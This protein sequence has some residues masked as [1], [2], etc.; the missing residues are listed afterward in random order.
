MFNIFF[1]YFS[2]C[3]AD[4]CCF[5][6]LLLISKFQ[7]KGQGVYIFN[8]SKFRYYR[9]QHFF[10]YQISPE[11]YIFIISLHLYIQKNM[12]FSGI[13]RFSIKNQES[14]LNEKTWKKMY[15]ILGNYLNTKFFIWIVNFNHTLMLNK[16]KL[17][18]EYLAVL[19]APMNL[20]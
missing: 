2:H 4:I 15:L 6:F 16:S 12:D 1:R 9:Y 19:D 3:K 11:A 5:E 13:G 8:M 14:V 18:F 17:E 10:L 20:L 7:C